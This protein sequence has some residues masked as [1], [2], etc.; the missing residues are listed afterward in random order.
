MSFDPATAARQGLRI[1]LEDAATPT[2]REEAEKSMTANA[3]AL[4]ALRLDDQV[5]E[6]EDEEWRAQERVRMGGVR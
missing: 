5:T 1:A 4:I 6:H 2:R 3:L